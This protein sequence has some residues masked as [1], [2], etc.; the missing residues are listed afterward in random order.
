[1]SV[2][3]D[4]ESVMKVGNTTESIQSDLLSR[5][6]N[7]SRTPASTNGPVGEVSAGDRIELSETTRSL[8]SLQAGGRNDDEVRAEKVAEVRQ[9]ISEGRFHVRAEAVA[10][11]MI[12]QAAELIE[13]I[14]SG[15]GQ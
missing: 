2:A 12:S 14:A 6:V 8:A 5:A 15:R 9:A 3:P 7:G 11:K 13:A 1:M 4:G 10:D